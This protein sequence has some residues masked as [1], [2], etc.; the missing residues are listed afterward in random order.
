MGRD[1]HPRERRAAAI[2]RKQG[3]RA[4][5]DRILIVSEGSKTE[6]Q[7]FCEIKQHYRLHTANVQVQPSQLGTQ[8]IQVVAFAE[9]LFLTGDLSKDIQPRAFERVYAVFDRDDHATYHDALSKAAALDGTLR[10]DLKQFVRF[11][12]I[13]SVPCFELWLLLH[14]E[15]VL[16]PLHRNE[17]Y[18]RLRQYLPDYNKGQP[19]HFADTRAYL[20]TATQRAERL[21]AQANA[22]NGIE[23]CTD[24]HRL[25]TLLTT[26]KPE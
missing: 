7:Y 17:V 9:Q 8:P 2:Q 23:S 25:V 6:P 14:F 5:Y 10:N 19:G 26:L 18:Q 20:E 16:A 15:D 24:I 13:A 11:Q 4:T 3:K 12:A 21:A 1:N 22:H